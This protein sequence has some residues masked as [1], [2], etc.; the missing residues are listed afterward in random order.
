VPGARMPRPGQGRSAV[1]RATPG[2]VLEPLPVAMSGGSRSGAKKEKIRP[3]NRRAMVPDVPA[4]IRGCHE[5]LTQPGDTLQLPATERRVLAV[6]GH[7]RRHSRRSGTRSLVAAVDA[8]PIRLHPPR[9]HLRTQSR[10]R[11]QQPAA[12]S[13]RRRRSR[14]GRAGRRSQPVGGKPPIERWRHAEGRE[15]RP[16]PRQQGSPGD[17]NVW[18]PPPNV[19]SP[20][21]RL[22]RPIVRHD[23]EQ[24]RLSNPSIQSAPA[25]VCRQVGRLPGGR[26]GVDPA[27]LTPRL[28]KASQSAS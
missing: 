22:Q 3:M 4:A 9:H 13:L 24:G 16:H 25:L 8:F 21:R 26:T 19:R 15:P 28:W 5:R 10:R 20:H 18:S 6:R 11:C 14:R 23:F 17:R 7:R 27:K 12:R 1:R 2:A